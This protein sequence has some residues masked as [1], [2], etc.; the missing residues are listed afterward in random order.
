MKET[1]ESKGANSYIGSNTLERKRQ[2][3]RELHEIQ[4]PSRTPLQPKAVRQR[5]GKYLKL[6][7][8]AFTQLMEQGWFKC[9]KDE[10]HL[11]SRGKA[12]LSIFL[13]QNI[14]PIIFLTL[15]PLPRCISAYTKSP[16]TLPYQT[17]QH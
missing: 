7:L 11:F 15:S 14:S 5:Q 10:L 4:R 6:R 1:Q 3:Q 2:K 9:H 17:V 13:S 8:T 16:A 12:D